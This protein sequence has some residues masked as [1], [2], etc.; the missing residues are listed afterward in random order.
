M[1]NLVANIAKGVIGKFQKKPTMSDYDSISW[2]KEKLLKHQDDV[3]VKQIGLQHFKLFYKRP[4]ELLHTYKEIFENEIYRFSSDSNTP[5]IIDCGAN[6]GLSAIYF[7]LLY[8]N[9]MVIAFEP[10]NNN[11][12]LLKKNIELNNFKN[13]ELYKKAVW[14]KDGT[15]SFEANE[16]EAS[17]INEEKADD[18]V[19]VECIKLASFLSHYPKIDFLKMD[20]EGAEDKVIDDCSDVLSNIQNMFIEYHGKTTETEKLTKMLSLFEEKGF[21]V[22]IK[23]AADELKHPFIEKETPYQYDVQL[24]IFCYK[25]DN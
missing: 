4:Y 13:V 21:L 2:F 15:I 1:S 20:I 8:P 7:K 16:S 18:A 23:N 6:I 11:F 12:E 17:R 10:D 22:Y 14:T 19:L 3:N 5:V 25:K 24:N 9:S